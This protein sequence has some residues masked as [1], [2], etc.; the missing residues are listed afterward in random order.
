MIKI[1]EVDVVGIKK[2]TSKNG[3]AIKIVYWMG[4][5]DETTQGVMCGQ[6][7]VPDSQPIDLKRKIKIAYTGKGWDYVG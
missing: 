6:L 1:M 2:F 3:N 5:G 7:F 4:D